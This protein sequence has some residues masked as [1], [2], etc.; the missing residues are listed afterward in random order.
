MR[1]FVE[2]LQGPPGKKARF[3][4]GELRLLRKKNRNFFDFA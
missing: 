2:A 4:T 3:Q 1:G